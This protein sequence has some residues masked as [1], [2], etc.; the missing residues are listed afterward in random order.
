MRCTC[1]RVP[2][3]AH[4]L[5]SHTEAGTHIRTRTHARTHARLQWSEHSTYTIA[6]HHPLTLYNFSGATLV[7]HCSVTLEP[8]STY[9]RSTKCASTS[10]CAPVRVCV[11]LCQVSGE[12]GISKMEMYCLDGRTKWR[13]HRQAYF[14]QPDVCKCTRIKTRVRARFCVCVCVCIRACVC[15]AHK[16]GHSQIM[17]SVRACGR[18]RSRGTG[19]RARD[20]PKRSRIVLA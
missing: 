3:K 16:V 12:G 10:D 2:Q 9:L 15:V 8:F 13:A 18:H 17:S 11:C 1:A 5:F 14:Y 6:E 4:I 7:S 19:G 20:T